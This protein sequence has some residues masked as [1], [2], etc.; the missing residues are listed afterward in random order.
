MAA[1]RWGGRDRPRTATGCRRGSE[2]RRAPPRAPEVLDRDRQRPPAW[3]RSMRRAPPGHDRTRRLRGSRG[4]TD[5]SP[6]P[7]VS[8]GATR[9]RSVEDRVE[10]ADE[11]TRRRGVQNVVRSH[12]QDDQVRTVP[13]TA[14]AWCSAGRRVPGIRPEPGCTGG[15]RGPAVPPAERSTLRRRWRPGAGDR[16]VAEHRDVAAR[17]P[18][19]R[20]SVRSDRGR[21][22][23]GGARVSHVVSVP[24]ARPP[25][26]APRLAPR[27]PPPGARPRQCDAC[28]ALVNRFGRPR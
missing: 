1:L 3:R 11:V 12:G 21:R 9:V 13:S 24:T 18:A 17:A 2:H 16:A 20:R 15:R 26:R 4:M 28:R 8:T 25:S 6:M 7:N 19:D 22:T 23:G 14:G 10:L 27:L 5:R